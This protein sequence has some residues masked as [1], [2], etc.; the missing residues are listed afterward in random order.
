M[1]RVKCIEEIFRPF[2]SYE[3]AFAIVHVQRNKSKA[4]LPFVDQPTASDQRLSWLILVQPEHDQQENIALV[5]VICLQEIGNRQK[6]QHAHKL[7]GW[8]FFKS[9]DKT[10]CQITKEQCEKY[11]LLVCKKQCAVL[12]KIPGNL[13][14]T[15]ENQKISSIFKAVM[16]MKKALNE[17]KTEDGK[18]SPPHIPHHP[19]QRI[20]DASNLKP[21]SGDWR[22]I[23]QKKRSGVINK[24]NRHSQHLQGASA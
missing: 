15:R 13:G 4:C 1:N 3:A 21:G 14:N 9:V 7:H 23:P 16:G 10:E 22:I 19:V 20:G 18:R 8:I 6:R 5:A 24:H 11:I 2:S 12:C 17:K